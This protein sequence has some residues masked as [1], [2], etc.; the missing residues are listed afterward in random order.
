MNS[1]I[2]LQL[3]FKSEHNSIK[4]LQDCQLPNFTVI[5]GVNGSGKTQLLEAIQQGKVAID[6]L[7]KSD[8]RY[9]NGASF[10]PHINENASP[11]TTYQN[12]E[13]ALKQ[14]ETHRKSSRSQILNFFDLHKI[15]GS[16]C[17]KETDWLIIAT[18][19]EIRELLAS[20]TRSGRAIT[21]TESGTLSTAFINHRFT[22]NKNF[23]QH[24]KP[25]GNLLENLESDKSGHKT[26]ILNLEKNHYNSALPI[27]WSSQDMLQLKLSEWFAAW[28]AAYEYNKINKYYATQEGAS[29]KAWISEEDFRKKYG[30]EPWLLTNTVLED[31]GVRYRFNKPDKKLDELHVAFQLK[32]TDPEDETIIPAANLS[33][34]E[35]VLLA[36]TLLLYQTT[37][38]AI[39]ANLPKV[40]LLDEVDAPLHPSFTRIL[41]KI[42]NEELVVRCGTSVIMTTHSPS[43]AALSPDGSIYEL[44]RKPR[45]LRPINA[46]IATQILSSGFIALAPTDIIVI[47]ESGADVGYYNSTYN[48]LVRESHITDTPNLKFI[49]ASKS[50]RQNS[51]GG[52][53]QVRN[54]APKLASLGIGR[55][56]GL[57]DMDSGVPEDE[58]VSVLKRYNWENYL[59]DP[60][61]LFAYIIHRCILLPIKNSS[62]LPRN[63]TDLASLNENKIQKFLDCFIEWLSTESNI[64]QISSSKKKSCNYIGWGDIQIPEW[65]ITTD[66]KIIESKIREVLNN[67]SLNQKRGVLMKKESYDEI[68]QFQSNAMP[69]LISQDLVVIFKKLK[70]LPSA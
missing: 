18:E 51:S 62:E 11:H 25:Y 14:I 67:L 64:P 49:P 10:A 17:L 19:Q 41:I 12:R 35:K 47:T 45:H 1:Q 31:A 20:C 57:V 65:W 59:F 60:L 13:N 39:L 46:S 27:L 4:G 9:Y 5:T 23:R 26:P 66:G 40:L 50:E 43:T 29:D 6:G 48:S 28:H 33:P 53:T 44:V 58:I 21:E 34:G 63:G 37:E 54:W 8:I 56:K 2:K 55:F 15:N 24:L 42:L 38:Q 32:L 70:N 61:T 3:R 36:I 69:K 22:I 7:D 30:P 16:H 52:C 68:L